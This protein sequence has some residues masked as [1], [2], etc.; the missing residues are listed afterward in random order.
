MIDGQSA[1]GEDFVALS[2]QGAS[3]GVKGLRA[4][5]EDQ[6]THHVFDAQEH[7]TGTA[8]FEEL[9]ENKSGANPSV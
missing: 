4:E 3:C 2:R 5:I 1:F 8:D 9:T 7:S 6:D